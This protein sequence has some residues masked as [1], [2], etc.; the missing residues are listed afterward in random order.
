[1]LQYAL[2]KSFEEMQ[3]VIK[4]A[5]KDLNNDNLKKEAIKVA[6]KVLD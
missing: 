1:M 3:T 4:L 6:Q 5:E 2:K